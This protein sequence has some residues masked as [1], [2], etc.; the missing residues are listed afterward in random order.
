MPNFVSMT[1]VGKSTRN[2]DSMNKPFGGIAKNPFGESNL[3]RNAS[4]NNTYDNYL[5]DSMKAHARM[6]SE[7]DSTLRSLGTKIA[8]KPR[9]INEEA[10]LNDEKE[11]TD[12]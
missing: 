1:S 9:L 12:D 7:L 6:T 11:K 2:Q 3:N 4:K 10:I 8:S 5:N